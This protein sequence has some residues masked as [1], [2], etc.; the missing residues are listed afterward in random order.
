MTA[1]LFGIR[2]AGAVAEFI[3][4][5]VSRGFLEI[6]S[7]GRPHGNGARGR[8][9]V[10]RLIHRDGHTVGDAAGFL[11]GLLMVRIPRLA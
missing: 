6:V 2:S 10:Y 3:R 4:K 9:T 11:Y 8:G 1:G 5:A 7:R